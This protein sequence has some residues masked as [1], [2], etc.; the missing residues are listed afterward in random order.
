MYVCFVERD[1]VDGK[2]VRL[3][4]AAGWVAIGMGAVHVVVAP[5]ER[6]DVWSQVLGDGVWNTFTL[7]TPS[8]LSEFERAETFWT[9]FGSWGVPTLV[10]GGYVVWS[11]RQGH[12]VPGWLGWT[13]LAWGAP[14]VIVLPASPGWAFPL[15]G[16]LIALGDRRRQ[17]WSP[18]QDP[19]W[20]SRARPRRFVKGSADSPWLREQGRAGMFA[21]GKR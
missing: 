3:V 10:F 1:R 9:T 20:P 5:L 18:S 12:R 16:G 15:I 4:Q 19:Q 21:G 17:G 2:S 8:T 13:L 14:L 6:G 11:A 7:K